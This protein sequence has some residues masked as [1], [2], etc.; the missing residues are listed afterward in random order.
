VRNAI[1]AALLLLAACDYDPGGRC[2]SSRDCLS[3]QVC[4]A[5][6]CTA[7]GEPPP[8]N[9]PAA[10]GDAYTATADVVLDVPAAGGVLQND[11]DPDGDPLSAERVAPPAH[12]VVY[13]APDGAFVYVPHSGFTGDDAF[14]YRAC[15]GA[16]RS[17]VTT[18]TLTVGP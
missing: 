14:T 9:P 15:D 17:D 13:V 4:A 1:A 10:A 2:T 7:E 5:G 12:G 6:L 8:N 3:A 16:L 11:A 18:V